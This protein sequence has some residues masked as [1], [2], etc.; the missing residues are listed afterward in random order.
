ML[1]LFCAII[2]KTMIIEYIYIYIYIYQ[3]KN[4]CFN[5][6]Y[7]SVQNI[8][9]SINIYNVSLELL[10]EMHV[11]LHIKYSLLLLHLNQNW[12]MVINL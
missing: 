9:P 2:A 5:S 4:V 10:T 12:N 6:I 11:G 7:A 1:A 3:T 8:F